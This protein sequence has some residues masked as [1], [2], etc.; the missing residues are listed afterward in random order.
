MFIQ[1]WNF[2]NDLV[3][4]CGHVD[5]AH[6]SGDHIHQFCEFILVREGEIEITVDG[7]TYKAKAGDIAVIPP[8]SIHSFY[9]PERVVQLICVCSNSSNVIYV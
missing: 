1:N 2:G 4:R 7:R 9:T 3:F 8:F 6:N 5:G